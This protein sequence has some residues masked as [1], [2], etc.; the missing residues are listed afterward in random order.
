MAVHQHSFA[1]PVL[2]RADHLSRFELLR[3]DLPE[4]PDGLKGR[5]G[6]PSGGRREEVVGVDVARTRGAVFALRTSVLLL[7]ACFF[8]M[9]MTSIWLRKER[10]LVFS[11]TCW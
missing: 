7:W 9:F 2:S 11:I 1:S 3:V 10:L 8:S 6:L 5:R 4:L